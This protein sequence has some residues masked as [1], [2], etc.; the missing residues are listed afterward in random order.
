MSAEGD[1]ND[2]DPETGFTALH[3]AAAGGQPEVV[4]VREDET[5]KRKI[6]INTLMPVNC[7][8]LHN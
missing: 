7:L 3:W 5:H 4:A 6:M 8:N 2:A 1:A